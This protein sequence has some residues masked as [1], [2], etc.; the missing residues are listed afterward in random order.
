[1][2]DVRTDAMLALAG[3]LRRS[4]TASARTPANLRVCLLVSSLFEEREQV[5][6]DDL[7]MGREQ[8]VR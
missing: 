7:M 6:V 8:A 5:R 3:E 1:M 4:S 2:A